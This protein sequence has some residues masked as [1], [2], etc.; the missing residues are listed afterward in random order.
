MS[1]TTIHR[2]GL[3]ACCTAF[4]SEHGRA[5]L[6]AAIATL[7]ADPFYSLMSQFRTQDEPAYCGLATL[8][9]VL[10]AMSIDPQR[11]WKGVLRWF[12]E[13]MLSCCKPLASVKTEG[14]NLEE[15]C[16]LARCNG[17]EAD[18]Y[19]GEDVSLNDFRFHLTKCCACEAEGYFC[20]NYDRSV[21]QQTGTGHFSPI[22]AY[23]SE[24]DSALVLD[25]ARFKY[26]PHWVGVG[27]LFQACKDKRGFAILRPGKS[28]IDGSGAIGSEC[29]V[30]ANCDEHGTKLSCSNNHSNN[31]C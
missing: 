5:R 15:F 31:C 16:C 30:L 9:M 10:N 11:V 20:L 17:A 25:T 21:V 13:E 2:R 27:L 6:A 28:R 26:P 23:D 22:A 3:P 7:K 18:L 1:I 24:T 19:K 8:V 12:H 29:C 14:I 4:T